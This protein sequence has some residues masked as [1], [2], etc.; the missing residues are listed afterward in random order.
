M[1]ALTDHNTT[2]NCEATIKAGEKVGIY[3]IPGMELTTSEDI[4]VVCLFKDSDSASKF[5]DYVSEHLFHIKNKSEIYG[6]QIVM[7]END[8]EISEID[9][10][11][12]MATDISIMNVKKI[13]NSFGGIAYPA[14]IDRDSM[15]ILSVLSDFPK[16]CEFKNYEVS[17][18]SDNNELVNKYEILKNLKMVKSSDAHYLEHMKDKNYYFELE[19][20]S[21]DSLKKHLEN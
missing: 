7:N 4:H 2:K 12:I 6:R 9:D 19:D 8:E 11:L 21:F 1:I 14:H 18:D 20:I 10:L 17:Y 15:S 3:V 5:N 16:E 13:V